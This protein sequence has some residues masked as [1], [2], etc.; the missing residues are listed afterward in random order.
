[1]TTLTSAAGYDDALAQRPPSEDT[2]PFRFLLGRRGNLAVLMVLFILVLAFMSTLIAMAYVIGKT[3]PNA[4]YELLKTVGICGTV[5][6]VIALLIRGQAT[7]EYLHETS[8]D[9]RGAMNQTATQV[10]VM[11]AEA[12]CA[13]EK[14]ANIA[15]IR[16]TGAERRAEEHDR[17]AAS[18]L[19]SPRFEELLTRVV[20]RTCGKLKQQ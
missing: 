2:M 18:M 12:R 3:D 6:G 4:R 8:H 17:I 13:A 20:E 15:T 19:E 1:M 14:A 7:A 9:L 5:L 16:E 10:Q 11:T